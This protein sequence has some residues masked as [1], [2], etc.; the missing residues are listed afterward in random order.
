M[1][2]RKQWSFIVGEDDRWLWRVV[3]PDGSQAASAGT[4]ST[5]QQCSADAIRNGYIA[6]MSPE[7]RRRDA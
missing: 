4:F 7:E 1:E 5:L 3:N 6:W 2:R